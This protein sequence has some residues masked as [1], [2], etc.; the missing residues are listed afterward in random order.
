MVIRCSRLLFLYALRVEQ[1][2]SALTFVWCRVQPGRQTLPSQSF[3]D[4]VAIA[5]RGT[6]FRAQSHSR[7]RRNGSPRRFSNIE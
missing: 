7:S 1:F 4:G 5:R 6:K 2:R 3:R